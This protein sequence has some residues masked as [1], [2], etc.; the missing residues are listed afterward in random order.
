MRKAKESL[1]P[2]PRGKLGFSLPL[3]TT[4]SLLGLSVVPPP[5]ESSFHLDT[6]V[7]TAVVVSNP[8]ADP[9]L[10]GHSRDV[11]LA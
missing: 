3:L 6:V 7:K 5:S 4:S 10:T 1:H 9:V 11:R 8:R 2:V